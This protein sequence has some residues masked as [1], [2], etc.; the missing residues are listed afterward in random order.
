MLILLHWLYGE[1][2][3]FKGSSSQAASANLIYRVQWVNCYHSKLSIMNM[4]F[5]CFKF[6]LLCSKLESLGYFEESSIMMKFTPP[7]IWKCCTAWH[8]SQKHH[9]EY[10]TVFGYQSEDSAKNLIK[11]MSLM[12]I[13]LVQ[14]M[15][16]VFANDPGDLGSMPGWV[17]P[18]TQKKWYLI[19]PCLTLSIII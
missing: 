12:V 3:G 5:V 18:K 10:L 13:M 9:Y 14:T 15:V 2:F 7:E 8:S 4:H 1:E 6:C 11:R 16:R 19:P 17:M